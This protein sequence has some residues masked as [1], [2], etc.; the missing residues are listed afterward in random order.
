MIDEKIKEILY[1]NILKLK[2]MGPKYLQNFT[3]G[4]RAILVKLMIEYPKSLNP[5]DLQEY[6]NVG[7]GRIGN[8][9]KRLEEKKWISRSDDKKDSR[10]TLVSLTK[11]GHEEIVFLNKNCEDFME[12]VI[13]I[14]GEERFCQFVYDFKDLVEIILICEQE[15]NN[16]V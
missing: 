15:E 16:N 5:K 10:K 6:L 2:K 12:K 4:E 13:K 7:S 3:E 1:K 8:A 9:L 14:F 11:E